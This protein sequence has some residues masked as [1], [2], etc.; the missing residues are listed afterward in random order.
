MCLGK[1][2][3]WSI[4]RLH[5]WLLLLWHKDPFPSLE[6][7]TEQMES[8]SSSHLQP[9]PSNIPSSTESC[10]VELPRSCPPCSRNETILRSQMGEEVCGSP[11]TMVS[12]PQFWAWSA[13]KITSSHE[14]PALVGPW[15]REDVLHLS[16]LLSPRSMWKFSRLL[17]FVPEEVRLIRAGFGKRRQEQSFATAEREGVSTTQFV[18]C[19]GRQGPRGCPVTTTQ[20][21]CHSFKS[22]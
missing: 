15:M 20:V 4:H 18:M 17:I 13:C 19:V 2:M 22:P 1:Q 5:H 7:S 8:I 11:R 14:A 6:H 16:A 21:T 3:E 9:A 10:N 12:H